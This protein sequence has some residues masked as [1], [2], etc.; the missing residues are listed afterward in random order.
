MLSQT[1]FWIQP[2]S[3]LGGEMQNW[4]R[5]I[6][7][8]STF[9]GP[10]TPADFWV[11]TNP[12]TNSVSSTVPPS[13][14]ITLISFR[15]TVVGLCGST[16]LRT[17]STAMGA[18]RLDCWDTTFELREV[19]ADLMRDS[20]SKEEKL[21]V[22]QTSR[23]SGIIC[24][25]RTYLSVRLTGTDIPLKISIDFV[26]ARWKASEIAVG[27]MPFA[28]IFSAASKRAPATTHTEVVPSPA[29]M[30]CAFESSTSCNEVPKSY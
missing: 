23:T 10:F 18:R 3:V 11:N 1:K 12:S 17:A 24:N 16:T 21:Y 28:S 9:L 27:W 13:F 2:T 14:S 5:P 4:M 26:A 7:A 15:S 8:F 6:L 29:S 25:L 19:E 30:S 20:L 22:G